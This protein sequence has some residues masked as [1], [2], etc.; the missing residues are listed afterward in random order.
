MRFCAMQS[1]QLEVDQE[2][3][4]RLLALEPCLQPERSLP[5]LLDG[6]AK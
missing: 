6:E 5:A 1:H 4:L 3:E 2:R